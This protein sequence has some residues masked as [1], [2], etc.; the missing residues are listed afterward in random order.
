MN[1]RPKR[2]QLLL[3]I[4]RF[5]LLLPSAISR[6]IERAQKRNKHVLLHPR[7]YLYQ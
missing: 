2:I 7:P 3:W 4:L 5:L 6:E 1:T